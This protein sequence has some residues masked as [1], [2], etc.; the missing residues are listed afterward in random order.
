MEDD[1][2]TRPSQYM[3]GVYGNPETYQ[4]NMIYSIYDFPPPPPQPVLIQPTIQTITTSSQITFD[5]K[6]VNE[7]SEKYGLDVK[8]FLSAS[9]TWI[10]GLVWDNAKI[11]AYLLTCPF[12]GDHAEIVDFQY[13][14]G[15]TYA[16][17]CM[18]CDAQTGEYDERLDAFMHWNRR[19]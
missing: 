13:D 2:G 3:N 18:E 1:C 5:E 11:N 19:V 14:D 6:M 9:D 15:I 10:P 8:Q 12:C 17:K 4:R 7:L 16:V